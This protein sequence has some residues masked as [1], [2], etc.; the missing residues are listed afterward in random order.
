MSIVF[1]SLT[2]PGQPSSQFHLE[3]WLPFRNCEMVYLGLAEIC[4]GKMEF[5]PLG[6][7]FGHWELGKMSKIK[8]TATA[9][10]LQAARKLT[11]SN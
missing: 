8:I 4:P 7:G 5:K 1:T 10:T 6:L 9:S 2:V 3:A 11:S